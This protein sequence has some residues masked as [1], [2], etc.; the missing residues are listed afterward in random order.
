MP[1]YD[2]STDGS[3]TLSTTSHS[4]NHTNSGNLLVVCAFGEFGAADLIT[5]ITYGTVPMTLIDKFRINGD[6]WL[7]AYYQLNPLTGTNQ[8]LVS[9]SSTVGAIGASAASWFNFATSGQPDASSTQNP[10]AS[11]F[12]PA[13]FSQ[14]LTTATDQCWVIWCAKNSTGIGHTPT[15]CTIRVTGTSGISI[16]DSAGPE[17]VGVKTMT[18]KTDFESWWG[19]IMVSF[20][21][22][23]SAVPFVDESQAIAFMPQ[24]Y[25]VL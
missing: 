9:A 14:S 10:V 6:R 15:G 13:A 11:I 22:P 5:G 18:M 16:A 8:V 20:K 3:Y 7:Y 4:F 12:P 25:P 19:G 21:P 1:S 23:V 2:N 24:Y 17:A